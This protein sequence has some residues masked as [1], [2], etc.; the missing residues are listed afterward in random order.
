MRYEEPVPQHEVVMRLIVAKRVR[1][2]L[3][4]EKRHKAV[5][6]VRRLLENTAGATYSVEMAEVADTRR[7]R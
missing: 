1:G 4:P 3:T 5:A 6:G 7:V 2:H